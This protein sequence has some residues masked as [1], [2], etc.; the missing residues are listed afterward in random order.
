MRGAQCIS[1]Q[2]TRG[3]CQAQTRKHLPVCPRRHFLNASVEMAWQGK[4]D[5]IWRGRAAWGP[6]FGGA[7]GISQPA[8]DL[9]MA[10]F[11]ADSGAGTPVPHAV[12]GA[13]LEIA[14]GCGRR[15]SPRK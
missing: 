13:R 12:P 9:P 14:L 1:M 15:E 7:R 2:A 5:E 11:P 4:P 6:W 8:L 3:G 10:R